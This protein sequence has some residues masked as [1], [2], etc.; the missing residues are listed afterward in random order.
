MLEKT[1]NVPFPARNPTKGNLRPS[2]CAAGKNEH[3]FVELFC[4]CC[5]SL[6]HSKV[7]GKQGWFVFKLIDN[8]KVNCSLDLLGRL[9][10]RHKSPLQTSS[11]IKEA[12]PI[13]CIFAP[14]PYFPSSSRSQNCAR[15]LS[16]LT[17]QN[18]LSDP[19][20]L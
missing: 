11:K 14:E 6:L 10:H 5:L 7:Q 8:Y 20:H 16:G 9:M 2:R 13:K 17:R 4:C 18:G 12:P 1:K 19:F 3:E 15:M